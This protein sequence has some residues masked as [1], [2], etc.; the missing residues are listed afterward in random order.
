[1]VGRSTKLKKVICGTKNS[2]ADAD[3]KSVEKVAKHFTQK[4]S[5]KSL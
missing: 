2:E 5:S 4:L 3:F 1:V